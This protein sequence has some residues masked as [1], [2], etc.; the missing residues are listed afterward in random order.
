MEMTG[1]R[2]AFLVIEMTG[3]RD[4]LLVMA[5]IVA[6][7][8]SQWMTLDVVRFFSFLSDDC[9]PRGQEKYSYL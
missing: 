3:P 8:P 1:P 6:Y 2:G 4:A 9:C 5:D 7:S